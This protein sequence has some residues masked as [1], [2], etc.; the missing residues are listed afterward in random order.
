MNMTKILTTEMS[1]SDLIDIDYSLLQVISRMGLDLKYAALPV[2]DACL[3]CGIDPDTFILICN[4]YSFPDHQP[5]ESELGKGNIQSIISYL[6]SSH[7]Y[8]MG[9]A[10]RTLGDSFD[11]LVAPFDEK[12]K[13]VVLKFF[14]DYKQELDKHF[15]YEEE[16]VFPY[17]EALQRDGVK[18]SEY[19]IEQ[20][21]E[22]HENVEEKLEDM[23]SIVMKYLPGDCSNDLKIMVLL[24]IYHLQD[25]LRRHTYVENNILVP[26]VSRL[27]HD[28]E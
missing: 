5:S 6:H 10:I 9:K 13:K 3:K 2:S 20:F 21:E 26:I 23:K 15:A 17:I 7:L 11:R 8:Y 4:V 22:H 1:V 18:A 27:E 25:D 16:V 14:N 12:Q 19:S 24:S 28:G